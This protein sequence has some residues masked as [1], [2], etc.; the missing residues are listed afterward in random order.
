MMT[1]SVPKNSHANP[2]GGRTDARV[3]QN[4]RRIE[5]PTSSGVSP[6]QRTAI[7]KWRS[8]SGKD[9]GLAYSRMDGMALPLWYKVSS[10]SSHFYYTEFLVHRKSPPRAP[11]FADHRATQVAKCFQPAK[12]NVARLDLLA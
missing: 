4:P 11:L 1:I 3:T 5:K 8:G 9:R 10:E 2:S 6:Q 12:L 7:R